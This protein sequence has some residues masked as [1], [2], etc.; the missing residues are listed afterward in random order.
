MEKKYIN[1]D[2]K[3]KLNNWCVEQGIDT[4]SDDEMVKMEKSDV[5]Y[6]V[7]EYKRINDETIKCKHQNDILLGL[8]ITLLLIMCI[9]SFFK[10]LKYFELL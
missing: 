3:T 10:S 9:Y 6:F 1:E 8:N 2:E 7:K 5:D 4:F